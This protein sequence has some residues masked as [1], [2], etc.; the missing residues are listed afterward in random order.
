MWVHLR[1]GVTDV[2]PTDVAR[3]LGQLLESNTHTHTNKKTNTNTHTHTT[4]THTH[5][6]HT[7]TQTHTQ[8][9]EPRVGGLGEE[10][11]AVAHGA[12]GHA[13]THTHTHTHTHRG[14]RGHAVSSKGGVG[15][16]RGWGSDL[17]TE[18]A[19][20]SRGG[21]VSPRGGTFSSK[22]GAASTKGEGVGGCGREGVGGSPSASPRSPR[23]PRIPKL[24]LSKLWT[25]ADCGPSR[26][27]RET[28]AQ[29]FRGWGLGFR[30]TVQALRLRSSLRPVR[31]WNL[32]LFGF[33][34]WDSGFGV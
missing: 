15:S 2:H 27:G 23:S 4:H 14:A 11:R 26:G 33:R 9:P 21:A 3:K 24:N 13:H 30:F 22:G 10:E 31:S 16:S 18:E 20:S 28:F 12:R 32:V 34:F 25:D 6:P 8:V 7:H 29:R 1:V 19:I 5:K 17:P